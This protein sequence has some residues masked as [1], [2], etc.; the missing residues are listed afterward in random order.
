MATHVRII[1]V[2]HIVLGCIGILFG[3][4]LFVFFGGMAALVTVQEHGPDALVGA[5]ILGGLGG[6]L[7]V[8]ILL[9]SVPGIVAGVGL[10]KFRPW[11]RILTIVLSVFD[12]L[13]VPFGTALGIYGLIVL[14]Q[15][16]TEGLFRQGHAPVAAV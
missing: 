2:L 5:S 7:L 3:L 16:E 14:L 6:F 9:L 13:N 10:L 1:G 4:G 11:A 12:L 8:L 15:P